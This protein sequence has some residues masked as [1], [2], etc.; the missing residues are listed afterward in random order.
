MALRTVGLLVLLW[1]SSLPF[2]S[3][4]AAETGGYCFEQAAAEYRVPATWLW[5]IAKVESN[6]DPGATNYNRDGSIDF[7]VMQINS[8]WINRYGLDL[9]NALGDPC[10]NIRM[11][12]FVLSDCVSRYG[13]TWEAIGCYNAVSPENRLAYA[14]KVIPVIQSLESNVQ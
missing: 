13:L 4:L 9:W 5:A 6:F 7:G 2:V 10:T 8:W 1:I 11:G 12:A 14:R 3:G